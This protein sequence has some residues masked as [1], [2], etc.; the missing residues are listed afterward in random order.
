MSVGSWGHFLE[1]GSHYLSCWHLARWS[2]AEQFLAADLEAWSSFSPR[3]RNSNY[4]LLS[5]TP[6]PCKSWVGLWTRILN[7]GWDIIG[8]NSWQSE[9]ESQGSAEAVTLLEIV[10]GMCVFLGKVYI[11]FTLLSK[12]FIFQN[13]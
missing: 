11:I 2:S 5:C 12:E 10:G 4:V 3:H 13:C 6:Q 8:L 1:T 9:I 7:Y